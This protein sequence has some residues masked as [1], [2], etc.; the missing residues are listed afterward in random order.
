MTA[1]LKQHEALSET[2]ARQP[3]PAA[4]QEL[5]AEASHVQTD[6]ILAKVKNL[7]YR[8]QFSA[9]MDQISSADK[10]STKE[11]DYVEMQLL[12][13][14]CLYEIQAIDEAK[15]HLKDLS[16]NHKFQCRA[17]YHYALGKLS[18]FEAEY[19]KALVYFET[20]DRLTEDPTLRFRGLLGIANVLYSTGSFAPMAHKLARLEQLKTLVAEEDQI[21]HLI[22]LGNFYR[23]SSPDKVLASKYFQRSLEIAASKAWTY[24]I[25]RSIYGLACVAQSDQKTHDLKL[26]LK[27]LK[28]LSEQTESALFRTLLVEKFS[29]ISDYSGIETDPTRLRVKRNDTVIDLSDRPL[30]F[31]FIR[32]LENQTDFISKQKIA[33]TLWPDEKY[34]AHTHDARIFDIAKRVRK[35]L[36]EYFGGSISIISNRLGYRL[37]KGS[38]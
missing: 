34:L 14:T 15:K 13:S 31:Q 3:A 2:P 8:C 4:D 24:F 21:S 35:V 27:I 38:T 37:V 33:S 25:Q 16:A 30:I 5:L 20:L 22:L 36:H 28:G 12:F 23:T 19:D 10:T 6:G 7:I 26:L 11:A 1:M 9:A 32:R 29:Q 18:Y 17:A